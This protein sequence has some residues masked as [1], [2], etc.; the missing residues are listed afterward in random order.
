QHKNLFCYVEVPTPGGKA[1]QSIA[2]GGVLRVDAPTVASKAPTTIAKV[3]APAAATP[4]KPLSR[5]E[6]LRQQRKKG[7]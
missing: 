5:L 7:M 2:P 1:S 4:K 6:E 3:K